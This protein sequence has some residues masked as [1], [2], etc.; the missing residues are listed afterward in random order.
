MES[1]YAPSQLTLAKFAHNLSSLMSTPNLI[2]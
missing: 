1:T 2:D